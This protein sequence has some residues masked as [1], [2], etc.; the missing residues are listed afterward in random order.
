MGLPLQLRGDSN[1]SG[2]AA[3]GAG[4]VDGGVKHVVNMM[5]SCDHA[6]VMFVCHWVAHT[7]RESMGGCKY[8]VDTLYEH[9]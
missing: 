3:E 2:C 1:D 9:V 7:C 6:H 4:R 5:Q 8:S